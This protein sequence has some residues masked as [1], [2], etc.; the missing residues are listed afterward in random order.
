VTAGATTVTA[1]S[2]SVSITA[3]AADV[4]G[5]EGVPDVRYTALV[6]RLASYRAESRLAAYSAESRLADGRLESRLDEYG[7]DSRL[8]D[9]RLEDV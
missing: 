8:P 6:S 2:A 9:Y 4:F 1:G 5:G 7:L 3:P